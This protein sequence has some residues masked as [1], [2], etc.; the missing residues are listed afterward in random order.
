MVF[1]RYYLKLQP[2][3]ALFRLNVF[4]KSFINQNSSIASHTGF[5]YG[6]VYVAEQGHL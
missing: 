2:W 5:A 6:R 3:K 1:E 4:Q